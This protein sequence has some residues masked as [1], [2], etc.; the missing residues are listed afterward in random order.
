[1]LDIFELLETLVAK[2]CL[3]SVVVRA[4]NALGRAACRDGLAP[5]VSYVGLGRAVDG[6]ARVVSPGAL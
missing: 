4:L 1:M 3:A 6:L 2:R 5:V